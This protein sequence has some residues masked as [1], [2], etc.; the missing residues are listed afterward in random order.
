LFDD[1]GSGLVIVGLP[2]AQMQQQRP[3]FGVTHNL[4]LCGQAAPAASDTSG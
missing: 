4:Q 3:P 1:R 2:F